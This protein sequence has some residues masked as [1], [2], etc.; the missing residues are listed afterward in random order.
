MGCRT[1]GGATLIAPK[2]REELSEMDKTREI[3]RKQAK[4]ENR[5]YVIIEIEGKYYSECYECRTKSDNP[6]G[7]IWGYIYP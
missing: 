2:I 6:E 5:P 1:C 4:A 7:T 3:A